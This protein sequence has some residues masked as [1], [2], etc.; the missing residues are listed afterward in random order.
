L[1]YYAGFLIGFIAAFFLTILEDCG[2]QGGAVEPKES[3]TETV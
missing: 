3:G 2:L 1:G